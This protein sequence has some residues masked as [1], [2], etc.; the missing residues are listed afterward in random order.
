MFLKRTGGAHFTALIIF[1]D[2]IIVTVNDPMEIS[3]LKLRL[4]QEFEIKDLGTYDI[5]WILR[6]FGPRRVFL[7]LNGSILWIF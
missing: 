5:F 4:A 6:W 2:D 1:V 3:Q 7:F